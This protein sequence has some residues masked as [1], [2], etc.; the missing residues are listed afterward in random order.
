[1][2]RHVLFLL[3]CS[4]ISATY[5]QDYSNRG[6]GNKIIKGPYETN[7]FFDNWFIG[8]GAG[9]NIYHGNS[10]RHYDIKNRIS[11]ALDISI[12]KWITPSIGFR[13][14]YSG[15]RVN[16]AAS[17]DSDYAVSNLGD[18]YYAE[19][20]NI[21]NL[22]SDVMWN[23]SNALSGYRK[24]RRYNII[25]YVGIGWARSWNSSNH[26]NEYATS[27]GVLNTI[28]LTDNLDLTIEGRHMITSNRL[29]RANCGSKH[30][31][32]TSLTVG[33]SFKFGKRRF[34]RAVVP[35][36]TSYNNRIAYLEVQNEQLKAKA[37]ET[38]IIIEKVVHV[39]PILL[40]FKLG[41]A[42]LDK[43]ELAKLDFY[44]KNAINIDKNRTFTIIGTA[45][46]AT[47]NPAFNQRLSEK[48]MH[49]VYY[50]LVAKH[51]ISPD[52]LIRK[53]EGDLNTRFEDS[54]QNRTVI[55]Q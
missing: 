15:L 44:V 8:A 17:Y 21:M 33:I 10:D 43:K 13:L 31:A 22:H 27:I 6:D 34:K 4:L 29:D 54:E 5:A 49:Y 53:A 18:G 37:A 12:G 47:G 52:R 24:D 36:Y 16:G 7:S 38:N 41:K 19:K 28:R 48:R 45:D 42:T 1:M 2:K 26:R 40:F 39:T 50:I 32:M 11:E 46:A 35:D 51:D 25:P 14:Q 9:L 23:L 55:I 3:F 30:D 20:F